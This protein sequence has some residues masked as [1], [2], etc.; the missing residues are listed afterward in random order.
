MIDKVKI[1]VNPNKPEPVRRLC[2]ANDVRTK[3]DSRSCMGSFINPHK[4]Q[5]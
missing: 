2:P 4:P 1:K 3:G 5:G